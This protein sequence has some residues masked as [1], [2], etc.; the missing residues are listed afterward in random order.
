MRQPHSSLELAASPSSHGSLGES[1]VSKQDLIERLDAAI[2]RDRSNPTT[3]GRN[4][5]LR[6]PTLCYGRHRGPAPDFARQAGVAVCLL[7]QACGRWVIPLT[8]RP[9]SLKH[10]GGQVCFPGGMIESGETAVEAAIR[11]FTEELGHRP[12]RPVLCGELDPI[13]VY[14]SNNLIRPSVFVADAP[15]QPWNPD[16]IEVDCVIEL[17]LETVLNPAAWSVTRRSKVVLQSGRV[18]GEFRFDAPTLLHGE[19]PIWGATAML[20]ARIADL[21]SAHPPVT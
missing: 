9:R 11:E 18:A 1:S 6:Y 13:Y 10:H 21:V 2:A 16:L 14:A 17:P 19:Y 15:E 7:Q 8:L 20:L 4:P 5:F 3:S 12:I